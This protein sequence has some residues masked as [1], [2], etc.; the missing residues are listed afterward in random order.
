MN[1]FNPEPRK[2][3][4]LDSDFFEKLARGE[5]EPD[6]VMEP[7]VIDFTDEKLASDDADFDTVDL[8]SVG[9]TIYRRSPTVSLAR[10]PIMHCSRDL[11][12]D[13]VVAGYRSADQ[14]R[15]W[16]DAAYADSKAEVFPGDLGYAI[17]TNTVKIGDTEEEV[18]IEQYED[19]AACIY[20][21][22]ER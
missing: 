2:D 7:T 13:L 9:A 8:R 21:P 18:W 15:E 5:I 4:F 10:V 12:H 19:D 20:Y 3:P 17:F 1:Q 6:F 16:I 14:L 11:G 22:H